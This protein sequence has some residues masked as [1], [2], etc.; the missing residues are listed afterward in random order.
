MG[1]GIAVRA[2]LALVGGMPILIAGKFSKT[3]NDST[4][5]RW[6]IVPLIVAAIVMGAAVLGLG[7]GAFFVGWE[8][9]LGLIAGEAGVSLAAW[10]M[11]GWFFNRGRVDLLRDRA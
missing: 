11:Y 4:E 6:A 5:L 8:L 10:G 9:A 3:T 2:V 1:I 7:I